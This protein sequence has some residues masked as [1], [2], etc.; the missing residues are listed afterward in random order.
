MPMQ[1]L[2]SHDEIEGSGLGLTICEQILEIHGGKIRL[3]P[4]YT[5]GA[6]FIISMSRTPG[7]QPMPGALS[8]SERG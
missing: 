8:E 2:H 5:D 4:D 3:D 7:E 1:R 6:R